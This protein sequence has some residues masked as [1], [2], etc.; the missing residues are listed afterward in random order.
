MVWTKNRVWPN[1][2][3]ILKMLNYELYWSKYTHE[4]ILLEYLSVYIEL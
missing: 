4:V 3:L 2:L 1:N